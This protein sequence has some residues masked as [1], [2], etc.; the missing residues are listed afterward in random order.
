MPPGRESSENLVQMDLRSTRPRVLPILP[1]HHENPHATCRQV[2]W[3]RP[4]ATASRTP[5]TKRGLSSVPYRSASL[6]AS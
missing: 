2:F 5:L 3:F 1:V 6:I 4:L